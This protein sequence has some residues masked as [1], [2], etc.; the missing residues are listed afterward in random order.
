MTSKMRIS[1]VLIALATACATGGGGGGKGRASR[2]YPA[3]Y[4]LPAESQLDDAERGKIRDA[5]THYERGLVAQQSGNVD[6]AR[7]EWTTAAENYVQFADQFQSSE[8]RMPVR[9][10]AAELLMQGMQFERAAEQAQKV[11][12]DP[13]ADAASKAV[14]GRLAAGAWLNAANQKVKA[15]QLEPIKLAN[16]DQ[17]RGEPLKPRVPP[18]EWKRFVDATDVYLQNLDADPELKKPAAERRGGL[19]PAQLALIGAEVEYAF[20]NMEDA[21]HR[22]D[23]ILKRWPNEADVLE[24]AVPLYLQTFLY[25]NDEAGYQAEVA[26]VRQLVEAQVQKATDPKEKE[27]FAKVTESL[28]RAEAGT[29]FA[30]AQKLL[31]EGKP[32]DAAQAFEKLASDPKGGDAANALH[33]AAVA[34][35]KAGKVERAAEVRERIL[36][37]YGDSRVA[38]NNMLLLAVYKSK[39]NDHTGAA[40]MYEEFLQKNPESPNRC[41]ALQN[42]ASELDMAK[43]L[44]PAAERYVVFGKDEKCASADANVAARALYRAGRLFE[45]AKQKAKAKEAYAAAV[46]MKGVTDTVAKSQVDDAKRR[47]AK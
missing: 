43:K 33:N 3:T 14:A 11:A 20:D 5:R 26:R 4:K 25:A 31:D 18:G 23:E 9:Y 1:I 19:P 32:A 16:A 36:K 45:D 7:A 30:A 28:S 8:W 44:A 37:E 24:S 27:S 39:K 35:D 46:A 34:W 6:Q 42:V 21:R 38:P 47:M 2:F 41:V 15:N 12:S 22:F 13:E 17:R 10:R 29:Q 40:K